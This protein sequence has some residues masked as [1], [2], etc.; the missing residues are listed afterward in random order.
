MEYDHFQWE[1]HL[2]FHAWKFPGV[3]VIRILI[4]VDLGIWKRSDRKKTVAGNKPV[5]KP[6]HCHEDVF[7]H[8]LGGLGICFTLPETNPARKEVYPWNESR[9]ESME[10]ISFWNGARPIWKF[11]KIVGFPQIIHFN[12]VFHYN[13]P[14]W[15][16]TVFGNTHFK[17]YVSF[18][19]IFLFWKWSLTE[20]TFITWC[21]IHWTY[22]GS[23][24]FRNL[25]LWQTNTAMKHLFHFSWYENGGFSM[26]MLLVV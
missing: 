17:G 25:T 13:H 22:P 21:A 24:L 4:L 26:A 8:G 14:F 2:F 11:P 3:F 20:I 1:I 16:T 23:W 15:C 5:G 19:E 6:L 9:L 7:L 18:R 10:E 12:R